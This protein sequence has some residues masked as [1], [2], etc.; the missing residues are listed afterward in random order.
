MGIGGGIALLVIGAI[1]S[2]AVSDAI[3]GVNLGLIGYICMGAGA[4]MLILA[5]VIN[6]QRANTSH[7]AVVEH[8]ETPPPA[9]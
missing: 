8:R 9:V 4:L 3:D 1:L 6:A 2:F 7:T 5:L